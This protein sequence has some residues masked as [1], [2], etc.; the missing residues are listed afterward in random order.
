MNN[1]GFCR[2]TEN[3]STG[4]SVKTL[5]LKKYIQVNDFISQA[6]P[7]NLQ[8]SVFPSERDGTFL[9]GIAIKTMPQ[10]I[11]FSL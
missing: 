4:V 7:A 2:V 11:H 9:S 10:K 6:R 8:C 3:V 1:S 5:I